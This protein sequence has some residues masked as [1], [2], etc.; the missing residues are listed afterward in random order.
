M[1]SYWK[2]I[3]YPLLCFFSLILS[4]TV[5]AKLVGNINV[6]FSNGNELLKLHFFSLVIYS[7][8]IVLAGYLLT[9]SENIAAVIVAGLIFGFSIVYL[10]FQNAAFA[11]LIYYFLYSLIVAG[12]G[13][14]QL[15]RT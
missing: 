12:C 7:F 4:L 11:L 5:I 8:L 13:F 10:L 6:W 2:I 3:V 14:S 9:K 15:H 1:K